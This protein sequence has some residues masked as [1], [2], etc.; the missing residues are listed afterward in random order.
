M[1]STQNHNMN[2]NFGGPADLLHRVLTYAGYGMAV[3]LAMQLLRGILWLGMSPSQRIE[4]LTLLAVSLVFFL[5]L[6]YARRLVRQGRKAQAL[7]VLFGVVCASSVLVA[8]AFPTALGLALMAVAFSLFITLPYVS[9]QAFKR[10]A[11]MMIG[12]VAVLVPVSAYLSVGRQAPTLADAVSK[13]IPMLVSAILLVILIW[14]MRDWLAKILQELRD[15]RDSLETRVDERTRELQVVNQS[16]RRQATY[17]ESLHETSLGIMNRQGSEQ[18]FDAIISQTCALFDTPHALIALISDNGNDMVAHT[19]R[20]YFLQQEHAYRGKPAMQRGLGVIGA[21]WETGSPLCIENYATWPNRISDVPLDAV[22]SVMCAPLKRAGQVIGV[23]AI[24]GAPGHAAF[25]RDDLNS[26]H[27]MAQL[28]S[29]AVDNALLFEAARSHESELARVV[30][31]RTAELSALLGVAQKLSATLELPA[32][33]ETI[34]QQ[35]DSL[36]EYDAG[37]IFEVQGDLMVTLH[38]AGPHLSSFK[39]GSN[40]RLSGHHLEIVRSGQP[41]IIDD[42]HGD[43]MMAQLFQ[44]TSKADWLGEV[45]AHIVSWIGV[46]MKVKD[47]AIGI[48][49]LDSAKPHQFTQRHA[50]LLVAVAQQAALAIENARLYTQAARSAAQAERSRLAR[51]LHDSVSQAIYGIALASRTLEKLI[52]PNDTRAG[53]PL[54]HILSL[55]EAA[56]TEIRALIFELRPES[57]ERE[58]ILAAL[59]KQAD[60]V[61]ARYDLAVHVNLCRSEPSVPLIAKEAIY[62]I[63][64]E[65]MHNTVKHAHA[66]QLWL[67]LINGQKTIMLEV[68]DDGV[69]FDMNLAWPGQM[70]LGT[71]RERAQALG[72]ALDVES[73]PQQ[74]TLVR[75][76]IPLHRAVAPGAPADEEHVEQR[77]QSL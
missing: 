48:L 59:N 29:I 46:P 61:R 53:V 6:L 52:D 51:D 5:T 39:A 30:A 24:A 67:S 57:L 37:T 45:P 47:R 54:Q 40:W 17:L 55:L 26:L 41:I 25:A 74:G 32:L 27:Q 8:V 33:L 60:A 21:V 72:G 7:S 12:L 62:R 14:Q 66:R 63:A 13:S 65:A 68:R 75:A 34:F 64:Q 18:L 28:A 3:S 38:Y 42:V 77:A 69:G 19:A 2:D 44:A 71:M 58:G 43:G 35:L 11:L 49:T 22:K 70:G 36:I 16:L 1:K 15:A 50:D 20:G 23:I 10:M 31:E 73:R 4:S 56:M 9:R 76:V